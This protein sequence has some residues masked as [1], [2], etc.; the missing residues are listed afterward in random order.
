MISEAVT[1]SEIVRKNTEAILEMQRKMTEARTMQGRV[2][3]AITTFSGSM[4]FVWVHAVWFGLW[5]LL[6]IGLVRIPHISEFDRFP[7]S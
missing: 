4:A 1:Q 7:F 2:A 6:N 5:I 3:D